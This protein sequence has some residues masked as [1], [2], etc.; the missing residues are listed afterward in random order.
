MCVFSQGVNGCIPSLYH[1]RERRSEVIMRGGVAS[2][3]E[4]L[5]LGKYELK[6]EKY[7]NKLPDGQ[8]VLQIVF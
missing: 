8:T 5:L 3:K 6:K 7:I 1:S 4:A 2:E